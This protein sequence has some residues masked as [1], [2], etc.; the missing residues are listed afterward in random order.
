MVVIRLAR[1]GTK[2]AP[3]YRV[4][5]ADQKYSATKRFIEI[6]GHYDPSIVDKN[7]S[8]KLDLDRVNYWISKGAQPTETVRSL[9]K[10]AKPN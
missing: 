10:R 8:F 6:V 5:V 7:K 3:K 1:S 9:I 2:H 4:Q